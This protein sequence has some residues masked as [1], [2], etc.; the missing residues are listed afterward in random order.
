M[1]C[2][3]CFQPIEDVSIS[4]QITGQTIVYLCNECQSYQHYFNNK[5]SRAD[6]LTKCNKGAFYYMADFNSQTSAIY[7]IIRDDNKTGWP[8][9][10]TLNHI[11]NWTPTNLAKKIERLLIFS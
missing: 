8:I 7:N 5:L 11:P 9:V 10:F 4:N 6:I 1:N 3:Y 2:I